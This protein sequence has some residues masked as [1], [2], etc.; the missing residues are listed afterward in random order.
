MNLNDLFGPL[1]SLLATPQVHAQDL[2]SL[3]LPYHTRDP[4]QYHEVITPYLN[5]W[6]VWPLSVS[7]T[8]D[9]CGQWPASLGIETMQQIID[10][11]PDVHFALFG[12][13]NVLNVLRHVTMTPYINRLYITGALERQAVDR[14]VQ[15]P[16]LHNLKHLALIQANLTEP[17]IVRVAKSEPS[18]ILQSFSLGDNNIGPNAV[19]HLLR[20]PALGCIEQLYLHHTNIHWSNVATVLTHIPTLRHLQCSANGLVAHTNMPTCQT[21]EGLALGLNPLGDEGLRH[22]ISN[23]QPSLKALSINHCQLTH[24]CL[25]ELVSKAQMLPSLQKLEL[26]GNNIDVDDI[27]DFFDTQPFEHLNELTI[28]HWRCEEEV[29]R[30][31]DAGFQANVHTDTW[32]WSTH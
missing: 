17:D 28:G 22:V 26:Q 25:Q 23:V 19:A 9:A 24:V 12:Q 15:A 2:L 21:L 16:Y 10:A 14:L 11:L 31:R 6:P 13:S 5:T 32:T 27:L 18:F 4:A 20:W 3:L 30:L 8:Y 29:D 7:M 1:R